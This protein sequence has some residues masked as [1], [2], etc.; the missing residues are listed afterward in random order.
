MKRILRSMFILLLLC[1]VPLTS[2]SET[3]KGITVEG[4]RF[5]AQ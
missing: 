5:P 3:P 1:T 2:R 4:G